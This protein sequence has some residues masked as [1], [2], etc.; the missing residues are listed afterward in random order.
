MDR[1]ACAWF[2]DEPRLASRQSDS[3]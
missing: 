3:T 1:R 2:Q